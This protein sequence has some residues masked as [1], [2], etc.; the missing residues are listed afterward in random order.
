VRPDFIAATGMNVV[1]IGRTTRFT[2]TAYTRSSSPNAYVTGV[3]QSADISASATWSS[4]N[5]ATASV[6][7][8]SIVG[9]KAGIANLTARYMGFDYTIP[10]YVVAPSAAA[11]QFAGTWSGVL[12]MF[13]RDLIGN[14]RGCYVITPSGA[15]PYVS[16]ADVSMSL[17]NVGGVLQGSIE[18]GG[19]PLTRVT[20]PVVGG[21]TANG[22]LAVGGTLGISG[23]ETPIQLRDW[24]FVLSGTQL[25]G[26]GTS[27]RAFVNI[28]GPVWQR[29]TYTEIQLR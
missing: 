16:T 23:H 8:R 10:V 14:T 15:E 20:G 25:I 1:A 19:G 13:C 28:Y 26:S 21:V 6:D 17:T 3:Q 27:D 24:H 9:R 22:E 11:Q 18:L 12:K 29:V 2:V 7:S 5:P 4:D